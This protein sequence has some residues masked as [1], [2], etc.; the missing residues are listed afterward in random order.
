[1]EVVG[2]SVGT[3]L[4]HFMLWAWN[5]ILSKF[6]GLYFV[7][8]H[9]S[10]FICCTE[11]WYIYI[12]IIIY[13]CMLHVDHHHH[14]HCHHNCNYNSS[15]SNSSKYNNNNN[16]N[17]N[18]FF[19]WSI[20]VKTNRGHGLVVCLV[21]SEASVADPLY[22]TLLPKIYPDCLWKGT[23]I[24]GGHQLEGLVGPSTN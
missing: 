12:Y 21:A 15:S 3:N 14:N 23:L 11:V 19:L 10:I 22:R 17:N 24:Q 9:Y 16:N 2:W 4:P 6:L 1:M 20:P 8:L 18:L 7:T 13:L 5:F